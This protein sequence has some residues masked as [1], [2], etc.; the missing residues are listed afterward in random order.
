MSVLGDLVDRIALPIDE[1]RAKY[2][3]G[4]IE[5]K[6]IVV[7]STLG[8]VQAEMQRQVAKWGVQE[9]VSYTMGALASSLPLVEADGDYF[10]FHCDKKAE[11][12]TLSWLDIFLEEVFETADE[13]KK[14]DLAKVRAELIQCAA[15]AMSWVESIDRNGH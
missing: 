6:P 2:A 11:N 7:G 12:G 5:S 4:S 1:F 14:K 9:H 10:K 15:V 8:E 13:A 3:P